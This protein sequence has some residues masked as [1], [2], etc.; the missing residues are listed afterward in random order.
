[1]TA[2]FAPPF[3]LSPDAI[4]V[5]FVHHAAY[6]EAVVA[7]FKSPAGV[8]AVIATI[9]DEIR[10]AQAKRVLI[11]VRQVIG[12]MSA[13]DHANAGA[14]LARHIGPVRCAALALADRPR[15]EIEPGARQ[16]GVD[17]KAFEDS[18]EAVEWLV[19]GVAR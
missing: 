9:G 5:R 1:M 19:Q 10:K 8:V 18:G 12:Q 6:L 15:G 2:A 3:S 14:V 13:T 7:G 17:Y 16:G 4:T 11:D